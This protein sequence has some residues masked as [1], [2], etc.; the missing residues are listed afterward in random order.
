MSYAVAKNEVTLPSPSNAI[1]A[2]TEFSVLKLFRRSPKVELVIWERQLPFCLENWLMKL[3][4]DELPDGRVLVEPQ[5]TRAAI[6]HIFKQSGTPRDGAAELLIEDIAMLV[7]EFASLMRD[8]QVDIRLEAVS[9]DACWKFHRDCVA[10]RLITTY[11]GATTQWVTEQQEKAALRE[12]RDF[13]GELQHLPKHAVALFRGN[14]AAPAL[15]V[16]HRSPPISGTGETRLL[17]CLNP[18]SN[19][20]PEPHL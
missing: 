3:R 20:S 16:V 12:Q 2:G 19:A 1:R 9:H 14:C 18:P 15:G 11:R 5:Y 6:M 4:P 10:G 17:L 13:K 8:T 7:D